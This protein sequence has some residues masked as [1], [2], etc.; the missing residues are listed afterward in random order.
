MAETTLVDG[1]SKPV[2]FGK[3][4]RKEFLFDE[5]YLNINHGEWGFSSTLEIVL[6]G[7]D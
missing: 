4:L 6:Q 7:V 3:E 2:A 5:K 1:L